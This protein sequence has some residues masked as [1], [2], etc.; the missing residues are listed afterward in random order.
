MEN[1]R[2]SN[3]LFFLLLVLSASSS[4][5]GQL[6]TDFYKS[7]CP[8]IESLVRSAV[9]QKFQQTFVTAPATLRLF[10]HDC[11]VRVRFRFVQYKENSYCPSELSKLQ[12]TP[13]PLS[14]YLSKNQDLLLYEGIVLYI[15]FSMEKVFF[16]SFCF[17]LMSEKYVFLF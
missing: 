8:N 5:F 2:N 12:Q 15:M 17:E 16:F 1:Q 14:L 9:R 4:A 7:T 13:P 10:F 6:K 11:F 3:L